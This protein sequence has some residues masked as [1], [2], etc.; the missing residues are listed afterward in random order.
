M[1]SFRSRFWAGP[2]PEDETRT[3][4]TVE[5]V[6]AVLKSCQR[7]GVTMIQ[8]ADVLAMLGAEPGTVPVTDVP[9]PDPLADAMTGAKWAGPPGSAPPG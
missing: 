7:N 8:V 6:T 3:R 2:D 4:A 5:R 1:S 9:L